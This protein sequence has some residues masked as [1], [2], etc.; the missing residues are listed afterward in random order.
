MA[1]GRNDFVVLS[2]ALRSNQSLAFLI[3]LLSLLAWTI[4]SLLLQH[5]TA[6]RIALATTDS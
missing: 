5:T 2:G 6:N 1:T 4:L 3:R